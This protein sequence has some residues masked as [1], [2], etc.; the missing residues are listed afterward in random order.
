M[1]DAQ[2][3]AASRPSSSAKDYGTDI[4]RRSWAGE[5]LARASSTPRDFRGTR[6]RRRRA[7][8]PT[9]K[10]SRMAEGAGPRRHRGEPARGRRRRAN[11]TGRRWPSWLNTRWR[12]NLRDRDL[13]K[14]GRD[15]V[16]E[17]LIEKAREAIETVDLR[18]GAR[19]LDD[20]FGVRTAC[21]WVHDKF[22]IAARSGRSRASSS[23]RR[24]SSWSARRRPQAYDEREA[25]YPVLAGLYHFTTRDA[26]GQKRVDREELV[27]WARERFDVEL[28]PRRPEEPAAR[29]NSRAAGRAQ[30]G[31]AASTA[32]A[33]LAEVHQQR[34]Q[35]VRP[36]PATRHTAGAVTG[37]N[38]ALDVAHRLAASKAL[39]L[40]AA[41]RQAGAGSIARSSSAGWQWPSRTATGPRCGGWSGRW[42]CRFSTRPGKTICWRW[43]TC[44]RASACAAT[45]RSI[46]RSSTSARACGLFELMWTR[47][48]ERVTD[49]IFRM[50]QLDEGFV[51]SHLGRERSD[52]RRRPSRP[53][54]SPASSRPPSP[55]PRPTSKLEPIRNRE[56]A[57]RPQRSLPLRQRQEVQELLH[58]KGRSV[59]GIRAIAASAGFVAAWSLPIARRRG[60]GVPGHGLSAQSV[61]CGPVAAGLAVAGDQRPAQGQVPRGLCRETAGPR[62]PARFGRALRLAARGQRGRGQP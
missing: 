12:L 38:G 51:G 54:K 32:N 50:E 5:L 17:M 1:I 42:S 52:P 7:A 25:E 31:A 3:D 55:A 36:A 58:A 45:P 19:F 29:R 44:A 20:D 62:A 46:P 30:P 16:A 21:A 18:D 33:A 11:G 23:P 60:K 15:D 13:K 14:I 48:G 6:L 49:L 47:V 59:G 10:P 34:R 2:V 40:R 8:W 26:S 24:S 56:R 4:V 22:G 27:A 39:R 35:A 61:L 53:A 43:T 41:A 37:G 57:R 9:T 28:G